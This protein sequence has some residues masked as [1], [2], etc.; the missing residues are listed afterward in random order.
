[1]QNEV[2][3]A[4]FENYRALYYD[5]ARG[6][7]SLKYT[8][9]P[10]VPV[11]EA[12]GASFGAFVLVYRDASNNAVVVFRGTKSTGD[13]ANIAS[14][15]AGWFADR[16]IEGARKTWNHFAR[17]HGAW[18]EVEEARAGR[19]ATLARGLFVIGTNQQLGGF[20]RTLSERY[21]SV[22]EETFERL[23]YWPLHKAL[24][25]ELLD[26]E[27]AGADKVYFTGQSQVRR[28]RAALAHGPLARRPARAAPRSRAR[29]RPW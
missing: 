18:G 24:T 6:P 3:P 27:L 8:Q 11:G 7:D 5:K 17:E 14:F 26:E 12:F 15:G 19:Y 16:W 9:L 23:G 20:A 4:F 25:D 21:P 1:M 28:P 29:A 10:A 13:F 2:F 22:G